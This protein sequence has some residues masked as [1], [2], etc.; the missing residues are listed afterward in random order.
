MTP[1]IVIVVIALVALG[2]GFYLYRRAH[3]PKEVPLHNFR[4]PHCGRKLHYRGNQA[5]H[6][7]KCPMCK[8]H[9]I[10]PEESA[11]T[12]SRHRD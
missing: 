2:V 10:Y 5:G 3:R 8:Q 6:R 11:E 1:T 12:G 9:L 7:A 4:C